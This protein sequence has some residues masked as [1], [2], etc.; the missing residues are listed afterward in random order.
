[1]THATQLNSEVVRRVTQDRCGQLGLGPPRPSLLLSN[2]SALV[3]DVVFH[4]FRHQ[5]VDRATGSC[6]TVNN[7]GALLVV[8]PPLKYRLELADNLLGPV[9]PNLISLSKRVTFYLT[10]LSG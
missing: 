5:A 7:L 2:S 1:M 10:V 3:E 6:E 4:K 9:Y 8:I